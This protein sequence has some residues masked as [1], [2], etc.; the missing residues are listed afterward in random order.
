ME[1]VGL[2]GVSFGGVSRRD[3]WSAPGRSAYQMGVERLDGVPVPKQR[4]GFVVVHVRQWLMLPEGIDQGTWTR[5]TIWKAAQR[6][7]TRHDAREGRFFDITW[8]RELPTDRIGQFVEDLYGPLVEMGLAVQVDW[9][10]STAEDGQPNDH[11]HGL[12]STRALSNAGFSTSKSRDVD[13]WFRSNIRRQVAGLFNSMAESCEI[14]VRFDPR[15]N[16][17]REDAL[18]PENRLPRTI[19]RNPRAAGASQMLARRD[20]QRS[21]RHEHDAVSVRIEGLQA[22]RS[23]LLAEMEA[24][25]VDMAVLTSWQHE[26]E[27]ITPLAVEVAMTALM[28]RGVTVDQHLSVN[29]LGLALVIGQTVIIDRGNRILIDGSFDDDAVRT[30]HVLARRKGWRD[31]SLVDSSGMPIPV[32]PDPVRMPV[33]SMTISVGR[34]KLYRR[35]KHHLIPAAEAV[36]RKVKTA[37][38]SEREAM[39]DRV[40]GWD[41]PRLIRLVTQ[42]VTHAEGQPSSPIS[43]KAMVS[44]MDQAMN[45]DA[46]LWRDYVLEQD[47]VAMTVPGNPLS[48]PF[49]PHPRF[50]DYYGIEDGAHRT[51]AAGGE[52]GAGT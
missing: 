30:I 48:R 2:P 37:F 20:A 9:E 25:L 43:P 33:M 46:D 23:S 5:E 41:N 29:V 47:L 39:L 12:I 15:P 4:G 36:V 32:P 44:M 40:V 31:L 51:H 6:A 49:H 26:G 3:G 19:H 21:L 17:E 16:V 1:T 7:E 8:P 45:G 10:T 50:Y 22:E 24:N 34:S 14:A 35:G 13:V 27:E 52:E 38:P 18:P 42:L 28:G 11:L